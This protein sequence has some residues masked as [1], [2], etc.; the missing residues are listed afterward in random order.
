[1]S[2]SGPQAG[3]FFVIGGTVP[4]GAPSY[5]ERAADRELFQALKSGEYCYVLNSRQMGKSSL[6][7][8]TLAK[9]RNSGSR[10]AFIDLT[11]LGG[12][13][14]TADQWYSGLLVETG[15]TLGLRAEAASYLRQH[16]DVGAAQRFLS[17]LQEVILPASNEPLVIFIDEIDA[18]RS[19]SFSTD[20][21]FAGIRQLY[22]ARASEP[23]LKNLTFCLL[24]AALPSDLIR[25][26]RVTPFNVGQRIDLLDFTAAEAEPFAS[27]LGPSGHACLER[28]LYW[29]GGHPF[30]TQALCAVVLG[31]TVREVDEAVASRYLTERAAE[32][33][34][35]L[36]DVAN[37]LLGR[38]DPSVTEEQRAETLMLLAK[39]SKGTVPDDESNR[40]AARLKMSGAARVESGKL[41]IRN[42]IYQEAF[43]PKWIRENMP[44][45]E[46]RRQRRAFWLGFTRAASVAGGILA[47]VVV[48]A[49]L[50]MANARRA[51]NAETRA[52]HEAYFASMMSLRSV[53]MD[54]DLTKIADQI[55]P[56]RDSPDRGWEW[57]YWNR[58]SNP[59]DLT[60]TLGD[61]AFRDGEYTISDDGHFAALTNASGKKIVLA[62]LDR[63]APLKTFPTDA[64]G[65]EDFAIVDHDRSLM[66]R[67]SKE[68]KL[69]DIE[70]GKL[71]WSIPF[72]DGLMDV[73]RN[74]RITGIWN[75]R[76]KTFDLRTRRTLDLG[77][78][79]NA[80]KRFFSVSP[81]GRRLCWAEMDDAGETKNL[82]FYDCAT[83]RERTQPG[84]T[85]RWISPVWSSDGNYVVAGM[86]EDWKSGNWTIKAIDAETGQVKWSMPVPP[87]NM[88]AFSL[89][90]DNRSLIVTG[91]RR[92]AGVFRIDQGT[93]V[94]VATL[95]EAYWA[96]FLPGGGYVTMY[97]DLRVYGPGSGDTS[98]Q[99]EPTFAPQIAADG[100]VFSTSRTSSTSANLLAHPDDVQTRKTVGNTYRYCDPNG[101]AWLQLAADKKEMEIE[102]IA[103]GK[104][105][106]RVPCGPNDGPRKEVRQ[107]LDVDPTHRLAAIAFDYSVKVYDLARKNLA[108][109]LPISP[110]L[111]AF[112]PDGRSLVCEDYS[113]LLAV[114]STQDWR[115]RWSVKDP[116]LPP[117]GVS[118]SP[119]G[120]ELALSWWQEKV[121]RL[122]VL[123][124]K[125]TGPD[126]IHSHPVLAA[127]WSPDE[128]RLASADFDGLLHIWDCKTGREVSTL[129]EPGQEIYAIRF[130]DHGR[131]IAT[132]DQHGM[133]RLW[134]TNRR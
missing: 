103:S 47:V 75:N 84:K 35:N 54:G 44:G 49:I 39:L 2:E 46:L 37:R 45:E 48:L 60:V 97:W 65:I 9:L 55:A 96:S 127:A 83:R 89:S 98:S 71:R 62:R 105:V 73:D 8:R 42:R 85:A 28:I 17:F 40:S 16:K 111:V 63:H 32:N 134:T 15:R 117:M 112:S 18:V 50:A 36:S 31:S 20:D 29:T 30:L 81:N 79:S 27:A 130:I 120:R 123:T 24:G 109:S 11:R 104:T 106:L 25:D 43:G 94:Q 69:F 113:G 108:M 100:R 57:D 121:S 102:D 128:K 107:P 115:R 91:Y 1:V 53:A 14:V 67:N 132:I 66:I 131:S 23:L 133:A 92:V 56:F 52:L 19:L 6:A 51:E 76:I 87:G 41:M 122:D 61:H 21:L 68:L 82:H 78:I 7:V 114:Y 22:N 58:R 4:P 93:A 119:S 70:T 88:R 101:Q 99:L 72:P 74:D 95:P 26:P 90:N 110:I 129:G 116:N 13:N 126:L 77:P 5:V 34:T 64:N 33:D 10:T 80:P 125:P 38:G 124:G 3:G 118:F 59:A 86:D 12:A